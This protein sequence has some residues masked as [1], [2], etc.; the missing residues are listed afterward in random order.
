MIVISHLSLEEE[1][2]SLYPGTV[3]RL[4]M[5]IELPSETGGCSR[6]LG[7]CLTGSVLP[8]A[9]SGACGGEKQNR[10]PGSDEQQL[11]LLAF[12]SR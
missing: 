9:C 1:S 2:G 11:P 3:L 8:V 12:W 6:S 10:G 5:E 4:C 7:Y